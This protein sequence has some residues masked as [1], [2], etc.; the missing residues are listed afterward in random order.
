MIGEYHPACL[1]KKYGAYNWGNLTCLIYIHD[2][3]SDTIGGK[4]VMKKTY[5]GHALRIAF[6]TLVIVSL[7]F[8][9]T[10][11]AEPVATSYWGY[12]SVDSIPKSNAQVKVLNSACVEVASAISTAEG[13]QITVPWED[14]GFN[15]AG[16]KAGETITFLVDGKLAT[17]KVIDPKGSNNQL[18]LNILSSAA[19]YVSTACSSI[20]GYKIND[21]NGNG[22]WDAGETGI[23][24]WNVT[25]KNTTTGAVI[26][27]N[28][29]DA[30]GFYQFM[31]L[32]N[33]SYNVTEE[34][35]I[36]FTPTNATFKLVNLAGLNVMNLNFTNQLMIQPV[37]GVISGYK[38][39]DTNGNGK[40]NAGEKGISNWIIKLIGITGKGKDYKVIRIETFTDD[41]GFYKFD[42]LPEG[43][44]IVI[45]KLKKG[46]VPT[47]SPVKRIKLVQEENSMNNNFTNRPVHSMAKIDSQRD[48]DD[49]EAINKDIEKYIENMD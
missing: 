24:G 12:V 33:G 20:S 6:G 1:Q 46:F 31:N 3:V 14:T 49:Y 18:S 10:S 16:V 4:M 26:A 47:S 9:S 44:Y 28:L 2:D 39:N 25:L 5:G 21:T 37:G 43:R 11:I 22:K 35:R 34:M 17:S 29:T 41:M 36:G 7:L 30:N 19:T 45:E 32:V 13:Y 42:N 38:I 40:W 8:I 27:S 48:M 23:Q 15:Q